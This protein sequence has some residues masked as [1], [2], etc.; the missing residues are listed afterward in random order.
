MSSHNYHARPTSNDRQMARFFG[1]TLGYRRPWSKGRGKD[2]RIGYNAETYDE[3]QDQDVYLEDRQWLTSCAE[4]AYEDQEEQYYDDDY[5]YD[6]DYEYEEEYDDDY[7]QE[8][9]VSNDVEAYLV[10][11]EYS[12]EYDWGDQE[13][14]QAY[15]DAVQ[16]AE[17]AYTAL[18]RFKGK[19]KRRPFHSK[20]KGKYRFNR[21]FYGSK[22]QGKGGYRPSYYGS[23]GK[24]YGTAYKGVLNK[25]KGKRRFPSGKGNK[26]STSN[27]DRKKNTKCIRCGAM[28]HW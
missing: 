18:G 21:P 3:G 19:G 9:H 1:T 2:H 7:E 11:S 24:R 28:G 12:N 25:G 26:N 8:E 23:K 15:A 6:D 22:G 5:G 16:H 10:Q 14:N 4:E 17:M 27:D 20:G 13:T